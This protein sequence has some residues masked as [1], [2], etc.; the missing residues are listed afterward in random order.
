MV[1]WWFIFYFLYILDLGRKGVK[2]FSYRVSLQDPFGF[3]W[4]PLE[5]AF[6]FDIFDNLK[7]WLN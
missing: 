4:H 7:A 3:N 5:G 2:W 6:T 1:G